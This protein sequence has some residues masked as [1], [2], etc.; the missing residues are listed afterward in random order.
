M[1]KVYYI[2]VNCTGHKIYKVI[3]AANESEAIEAAE[4]EYLSMEDES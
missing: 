2:S 3:G 1:S 4:N